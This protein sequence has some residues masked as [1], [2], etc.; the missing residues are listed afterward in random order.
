MKMDY[1]VKGNMDRLRWLD[2]SRKKSCDEQ[3]GTGLS[4]LEI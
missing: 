3:K 4:R 1:R 2:G